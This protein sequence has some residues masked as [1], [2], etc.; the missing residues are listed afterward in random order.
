MSNALCTNIFE[1]NQ[2]QREKIKWL[3][4]ND[5]QHHKEHSE[6]EALFEA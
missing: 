4:T 3:L 6:G 2:Y 5:E 1:E